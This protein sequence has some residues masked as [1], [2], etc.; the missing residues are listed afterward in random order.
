MWYRCSEDVKISCA[1]LPLRDIWDF[2]GSPVSVYYTIN[3]QKRL[4]GCDLPAG[5]LVPS[6]SLSCCLKT[7]HA[8]AL[9]D[10]SHR[11]DQQRPSSVSIHNYDAFCH[12]RYKYRR[13]GLMVRRHNV[14]SARLRLI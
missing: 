7:V 10:T 3:R 2:F 8:A 5:G 6:P 11:R 13:R 12:H 9:L 1:A 4:T 14:V